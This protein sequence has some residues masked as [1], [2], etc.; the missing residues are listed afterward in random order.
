M[1]TT[2]RLVLVL[3]GLLAGHTRAWAIGNALNFTAA[4]SS[5]VQIARPVQDD[6]TIEYWVKIPTTTVGPT[7]ANWYDGIG[8][9]DGEVGGLAN[10]FGTSLLNGG[11]LAFG[12]GNPDVTIQSTT[13]IN[14]GNWHHVAVTRTL[15]TGLMLLYIDGRQEASSGATVTNKTTLTAPANMRFG[16]IQAG[17]NYFTGQL[18]EVRFWSTVRTAAEIAANRSIVQASGTANLVGNYRLDE[19]T[20]TTTASTG[21][22]AAGTLTNGPTW[23]VPSTAPVYYPPTITSFAP[24][25]GPVGTSVVI[26]GTNFTGTTTVQFNG[27]V[28]TIFTVNS[29]TQITATVPSGATTG[30]IS[31]TNPA[32]T[33][34]STSSFTVTPPTVGTISSSVRRNNVRAVIT[35]LSVTSGTPTGYLF[36]SLPPAAEGTLFVANAAITTYQTAAINTVYTPQQVANL[37]FQAPTTAPTGVFAFNFQAQ[38]ASGTSNTGTYNLTIQNALPTVVGKAA[39]IIPKSFG[40]TAIKALQGADVDG[41]IASY[42]ILTIPSGGTLR[43]N[44]VAITAATDVSV[45]D[46]SKL[47][48][49]PDATIAAGNYSFTY[50]ATDN[51]G[52]N[53][54]PAT[55]SLPVSNADCSQNSAV[56]FSERTVGEDWKAQAGVTVGNTTVSSGNYASSVAAGQ[57]NILAISPAGTISTQSLMWQLDNKNVAANNTST[58]QLTFSRPVRNL[59][60]S[61]EDIDI[62][63]FAAN[64]SD[65]IDEVT[66]NAYALGSNTPYQLA[67]ADVALGL[68]GANTFVAGTNTIKGVAVSSGP[69]STVVLTYPPGIAVSRLEIIYRN[70]QTYTTGNDRTQTVGIQSMVW[71]A[72]VDLATTL[73]GSTRAQAGRAVTYTAITKNQGD[74]NAAGVQS[75]VQLSPNLQNVTAPAGF[76]YVAST[77]LLTLAATGTLAP[78]ATS[79]SD[80]T[81]TMPATGSVTGQDRSTTTGL[82]V[83][84]TNNNGSLANANLAT[85]QNQPPVAIN[86]TVPLSIDA[87]NGQVPIPALASTDP[88][89]NNTIASYTITSALPPAAQGVLYVNGVEL[90]T[91]NFPNLTLTPTQATQL[92]FDPS[93]TYL[94]NVTFQYTVTDDLG[95]SAATPATYLIPVTETIS[96]TVFEDVNYGG[97]AGRPFIGTAGTVGRSG[98]RVELYLYSST[99]NTAPFASFTTTD[100]N[101]VY[102][103]SGLTTG[104]YTVR[105]V[106]SSVTSSRTGY[107]ASLLPVQTFA[108][109]NTDRVGG[110]SPTLVDAGNGNSTLGNLTAGST[111]AESIV[112]IT[113]ANTTTATANLAVDFGFNFDAVVNTN[114]TEQG[115]L[116]QFITNANALLNTTLD[117]VAFNGTVAAGTTAADPAAGVETAIFMLNDGRTTGAPAGLRTNMTA[118]SGYSATTGFTIAL[119]TTLPTITDANTALDGSKQTTV[120]GNTIVAVAGTTTGPEVTINFNSVKG[121]VVTGGSTIIASIGLNNAV[122]TVGSALDGAGVT[123]S[124]AA[125]TGS[126]LRDVTAIGNAAT[127]VR[128]QSG[129]TGVTISGNVLTTTA[130]TGTLF[131]KGV[132]LVNASG[133]TISGNTISGNAGYGLAMAGGPND[134]NT[135]SGNTISGNGVGSSS[136]ETSGISIM[137]GTNNVIS[138]NTITGNVGNGLVALAGTATNRFTQNSISANGLLGIDL[139]AGSL[140]AG[141]GVTRNASGTR[142]GA[143]ALVNFPVMTQTKLNN[144]NLQVTGFAPVG[145]VIEFFLA[146]A[147]ATKFGEG[148]TYL[149]SR[150]EGSTDDTNAGTGNYIDQINGLDQGAETNASRFLFTIPLSPAQQTVLTQS[151]AAITATATAGSATSE[152]SGI[153]LPSPGPLPVEL[154]A[155][156]AQA[157][158][159]DAQLSWT[160]ATE[161]NNAFFA[162]ERSLDGVAYTKIGQVA[163]QGSKASPTAYAYLDKGIGAKANGAVYYRLRQVDTDGTGTYSL[164][165]VLHFAPAAAASISLYP[166]PAQ[167][168]T[169]LDLS[170]LP[171]ARTYSVRLTDLS[172]RLVGTYALAGGQAHRL[173]LTSLAAGSYLLSVSGPDAQGAP[174]QLVKRLTKE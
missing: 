125:V 103:F 16:G 46:V 94:G 63:T 133:N 171:S 62:S 104:T 165:R 53:S 68:N 131:G 48:Y 74:I 155:F 139:S 102:A 11:K 127:G 88:D 164:V 52:E 30:S 167:S 121:L 129:A 56:D 169:T 6:F 70:T 9:V 170:A 90:N 112:A 89:G 110:E 2:L 40:A 55:F 66:F 92:T 8:L 135:I 153:A 93:G 50:Q 67:A 116:R 136:P 143:N 85:V 146:A 58:V 49:A 123:F 54:A 172:G 152:F 7:S 101:G 147:N 41:T 13:A 132:N 77:G 32:G 108:G 25:S 124:A 57:T 78:N 35:K 140:A 65:F 45:A 23:V 19:G 4:T 107:V 1:R 44:G 24:A 87:N 82:D 119:A 10:D 114:N 166:V 17:G 76:T 43:L 100:A 47:T 38:N 12:V 160:T 128:L 156:E 51:S 154:T 137:V 117:Q 145:A 138:A 150:T 157:D 141:D 162:V 118:P 28:A 59:A 33:A 36:T 71:C 158:K 96:G 149:F 168:E 144:G 14:D 73:M 15:S 159:A 22:G 99:T 173:P 80:I 3:A 91:T 122:G 126:T 109:G 106:N 27:T 174:L 113:L 95:V 120:T 79:T 75:T 97:G 142:T 134:G 39:P 84:P 161:H 64:K 61:M 34:T 98:A 42:R 83:E 86:V 111:A 72:E 21:I 115:S 105:V 31:V 130:V 60:F 18:D 5:Y 151:G 81:F 148:Q 20:G 163:G 37:A 69:A 26:T 29:D